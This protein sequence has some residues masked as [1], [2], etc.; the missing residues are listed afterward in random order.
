MNEGDQIRAAILASP[1]DDQLRLAFADWLDG[2]GD[3]LSAWRADFIRWQLGSVRNNFR[4]LDDLGVFFML[5][6]ADGIADAVYALAGVPPSDEGKRLG[7]SIYGDG[8]R[9]VA[10][11][12]NP[13]GGVGR[14]IIT[15]RRGFLASVLAPLVSLYYRGRATPAL[16]ALARQPVERVGPTDESPH[17][18]RTMDGELGFGRRYFHWTRRAYVFGDRRFD[19]KEDADNF[20][21]DCLLDAA[22]LE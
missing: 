17:E 3:R 1:A 7:Q 12:F 11:V 2:R 15:Y 6:Q 21:S 5:C 14:T 22:R 4:G 13:A 19:T 10:A 9:D 20:L 16:V 8:N 18:N